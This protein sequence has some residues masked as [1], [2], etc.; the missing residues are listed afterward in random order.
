VKPILLSKKIDDLSTIIEESTRASEEGVKRFVE[1]AQGTLRRATSKRH[2]IIFGRRG[3]GKS[4][5]LRKVASDLTVKRTP[6]AFIDLE[7]FKGHSYPDVLLSVLIVTFEEFDKWLNT[8]AINPAHKTSFWQ[9]YFGSKPQGP[10]FNK[11]ATQGLSEQVKKITGEL[12]NLLHSANERNVKE[13]NRS[14]AEKGRQ[15]GL[16]GGLD[17][18]LASAQGTITESNKNT[19]SREVTED[20]Q[21]NKVDSLQRN[22]IRYQSIFREIA[23]LSKTDC[24][25][26]LDDLYHIR[27]TDQPRVVDYFHRI[28]KG[29]NL[30]L[31]VGTIR[32][33]TNWYVH[34]DP[35]VGM[36]LGD[37]CDQ[38]DLDLT[39]EKYSTT[40]S[41]LITI[42]SKFLREVGNYKV[43]N[44]MT[45]GAPDRL[46]LASGGVARD[47]LGIF[48]RSISIARE[49]ADLE[50]KSTIN[51]EDINRAAGEYDTSKREEFKRDTEATDDQSALEKEFQKIQ[52]F[53]LTAAQANIFL[54]DQNLTGRGVDLINELVDLRLIHLVRS[55]ITVSGKAG[56]LFR[57]YMLD[58]SQYAGAR[59]RRG[60]IEIK[61]WDD[62]SKE[63]IRRVSYIY[64]PSS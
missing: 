55:R 26:F 58:V 53:C 60:L 54:I 43:E 19:Q 38:I 40:K 10:A 16:Q 37:D 49:R 36:K 14:D 25:L 12:N 15:A 1:P 4:S 50:S 11:K 27:K 13:I 61:F 23:K 42:L 20:Y 44:I 18:Q 34:G 17:T 24:Y 30:W 8:A 62:S 41:F 31:K 22:I 47:F 39:L 46:V 2:H 56:S 45:G 57:A 48:R 7:K 21:H 6:I 3:S 51:V 52:D 29:N 64:Q 28:A 35:P 32:H 33:R 59:K 5:L 9:K 63:H